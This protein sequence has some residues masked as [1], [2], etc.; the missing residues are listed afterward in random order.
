PRQPPVV[1]ERV[2]ADPQSVK[3]ILHCRRF[4]SPATESA[5]RPHLYS[6]VI[7]LLF[8]PVVAD[9]SP[10]LWAH[11]GAQGSG[12]QGGGRTADYER[13]DRVNWH[14]SVDVA[15]G[16]RCIS[17]MA[18]MHFCNGDKPTL[19]NASHLRRKYGDQ[20]PRASTIRKKRCFLMRNL[21]RNCSS[22]YKG[23]S[24]KY[25]ANNL[26]WSS[27]CSLLMYLLVYPHDEQRVQLALLQALLRAQLQSELPFQPPWDH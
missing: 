6:R 4:G 15:A 26:L 13:G 12:E 14:G 11:I 18:A 25:L 3:P 17:A 21:L 8:D 1:R 5:I 23:F 22:V 9:L 10:R 19:P 2:P 24:Q 20:T 7:S 16:E 27:A